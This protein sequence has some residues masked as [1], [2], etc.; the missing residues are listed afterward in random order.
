MTAAPSV[1]PDLAV[2]DGYPRRLLRTI[3]SAVIVFSSSMT[4]VSASL[5]TM[6]E[7]LDS[8]EAFLSWA[9]TGLFLMMA[10]G[11]PTMGRLGD[12]LGH[13]RVFLA[14]AVVLTTGT[15]LC[16]LAP[17]DW[18][19]VAARMV[20][21]LGISATMPNGMALIMAA[22]PTDR[23]AEAMGWFQMAMVGA[24]VLGLIIGGPLIEW[25]GWR[26]VFAVL[27]PIGLAGTI[28][29]WRVIRPSPG[30]EGVRIDWAGAATLATATLALLLHLERVRV[31]GFTD[32]VSI[33]LLATSA[34]MA[35]VFVR[36]EQ[37]VPA[38]MLKLGYFRRRDFTGPLIAQP[39]AQFSYM[40]GFLITP[41][42][43]EE[44]FGYSVSAVALLLLARPLL[45]SVSSP[46][47]GR[48]AGRIGGRP[49]IIAGS[50]V[51]VVSML[52]SAAGAR[53][54][55]VWLIVVGL[56]LAGLAMGIASPSYA[57]TIASAVDE[58]D[59]GI[60]NGMGSTVMNIG[61]LTGIQSMFVVLGDG[62]DPSD[63]MV[64]FLVGT[65]VAAL[66]TVGG[67]IVRPRAS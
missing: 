21:G 52:A 4:L 40:G 5:P 65:A 50:L 28:A 54:E 62:R 10:V 55:Q 2:D 29:S 57:T 56:A 67:L 66:S 19:F 51:M 1:E 37:L 42:L 35:L 15:A 46:V 31:A 43:L 39:L 53:F 45:Y 44:V 24:P 26:S 48:F 14:G 32:P 18:A 30:I 23:R 11:T 7:D 6:A 13:R 9:V 41:L 64:V 8:T 61:M 36:V 33:G 47:G 3:L 38:P 16:G 12:L 63:F 49:M 27:T 25:L 34:V 59:L 22:Y 17:N 60:A 20:V 58:A